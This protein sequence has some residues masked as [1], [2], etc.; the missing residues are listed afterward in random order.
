MEIIEP[1]FVSQFDHHPTG[2]SWKGLAGLFVGRFITIGHKKASGEVVIT[3]RKLLKDDNGDNQYEV[4]KVFWMQPHFNSEE[5]HQEDPRPFVYTE[6]GEL[7]QIGDKVVFGFFSGNFYNPVIL[8]SITPEF[9]DAFFPTYESDLGKTYRKRRANHNR[10]LEILDDGEGAITIDVKAPDDSWQSKIT[11]DKGKITLYASD[12][13]VLDA[14]THI[15]ADGANERLVLGDSFKTYFNDFIL[16][17]FLKHKH[18]LPDG[19]STLEP[20]LEFRINMLLNLFKDNLL[21]D[22]GKTKK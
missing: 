7:I 12:K 20:V 16:N 21:S 6:T 10:V 11:I 14:L 4:D 8:G 15:G 9:P 1:G 18:S 3:G 2:P 13:V 22:K 17:F 5:G 19:T